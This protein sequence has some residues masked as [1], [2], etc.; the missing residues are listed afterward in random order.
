[1]CPFTK[2]STQLVIQD[3]YPKEIQIVKLEQ[4]GKKLSASKD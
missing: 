4:Q 3:K 2:C 1:M